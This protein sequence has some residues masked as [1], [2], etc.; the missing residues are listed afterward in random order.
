MK[1]AATLVAVIVG[2]AAAQPLDG[3]AIDRR[4]PPGKPGKP[5]R[6]DPAILPASKFGHNPSGAAP[7][8][9][10][11]IK[12]Q[13]KAS[14]GA[15]KSAAKAVDRYNAKANLPKG[16]GKGVDYGNFNPNSIRD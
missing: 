11:N 9:N 12:A 16:K 4:A 7:N 14:E 2:L 13:K 8:A 10:S 3:T 1:I 5:G 15:K 6:A